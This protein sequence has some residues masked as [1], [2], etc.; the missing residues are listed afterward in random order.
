MALVST[1]M[2][3]HHTPPRSYPDLGIP[4]SHRPLTHHGGDRDK[5]AKVVKIN[6]HHVSMLAYFLEKL[7]NTPDGD[8]SLLEHVVILYGAGLSDGHLHSHDHASTRLAGA[9]QGNIK[10]ERHLQ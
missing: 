9:G 4:D 7:K 3:A 5:I 8:G 2:L 6:T 1:F 10:G